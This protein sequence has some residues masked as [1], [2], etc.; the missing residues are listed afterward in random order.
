MKVS[1]ALE[2]GCGSESAFCHHS[3]QNSTGSGSLNR[4]EKLVAVSCPTPGSDVRS[5]WSKLPLHRKLRQKMTARMLTLA[6]LLAVFGKLSS[7][8]SR[9]TFNAWQ[10]GMGGG[11]WSGLRSSSDLLEFRDESAEPGSSDQSLNA[12]RL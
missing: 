8:C 1:V 6:A 11:G 9:S 4:A 2:S 12:E 10:G 7:L 3:V 5:L